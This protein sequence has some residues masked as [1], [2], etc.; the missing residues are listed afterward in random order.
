M[1]V[2]VE[3][4]DD[5]LPVQPSAI[6]N[7]YPEKAISEKPKGGALSKL[8]GVWCQRPEFWEWINS[9]THG[10]I[11]WHAHDMID[12]ANFVREICEVASRADLDHYDNAAENFHSLIRG[13]FSKYMQAKG[14]TI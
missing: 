7:N 6:I 13:P 1:A 5:E 4:G 11:F 10:G 14:I 3:V 2:L 12:A 8:A 9:T